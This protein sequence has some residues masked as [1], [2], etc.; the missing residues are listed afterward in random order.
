LGLCELDVEC[1]TEFAEEV[2]GLER[3]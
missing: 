2:R 3:V 1:G